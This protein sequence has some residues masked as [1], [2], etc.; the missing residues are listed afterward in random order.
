MLNIL[1]LMNRYIIIMYTWCQNKIHTTKLLAVN[2]MA[3]TEL[4][5]SRNYQMSSFWP[6]QLLYVG[7]WLFL[8][9]LM[10]FII[11][12]KVNFKWQLHHFGNYYRYKIEPSYGHCPIPFPIIIPDHC[13]VNCMTP[14]AAG[15]LSLT[16]FLQLSKD[17][18]NCQQV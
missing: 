10:Y 16:S 1:P 15:L 2:H 18:V 11:L 6:I 8:V 4:W 14:T 5:K 7:M 12:L 9:A 3:H 17:M 13:I